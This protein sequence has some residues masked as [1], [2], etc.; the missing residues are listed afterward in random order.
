MKIIVA[1]DSFKGSL[2]S[3]TVSSVI[4][5]TIRKFLSNARIIEV[6]LAD[7]GEGTANVLKDLYPIK[8]PFNTVDA[9]GREITSCYYLDPKN[10]KAFVESA[11]SIGLPLIEPE[12]RSPLT[13]SSFGLG[14]VIK[15]IAIR[16]IK[17]ITVSLGGTAT[18]DAGIGMLSALGWV[19]KD[20]KRQPILPFASS[21]IEVAYI[22]KMKE[23]SL[24][25]GVKF[26]AITDVRNPLFGENGA[27]FVFAP[28]KGAGHHEVVT[29]DEGLRH[30]AHIA[31]TRVLDNCSLADTPG[32]GAAGGLG[33]TF[34]TFLDADLINGIDFILRSLNFTKIIEQADLIITGEGKIDRQSLMGK[35]VSGV[36]K[37][38]LNQN[39]P[40]IAIAGKAEDTNDLKRAGISEIFE[41]SDPGLHP[42]INMQTPVAI[43]N[44]QKT[45]KNMLKSNIFEQILH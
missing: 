12:F 2:D 11:D 13:A 9:I 32:A 23:D 15:E 39:I 8:V 10:E 5:D 3:S 43:K 1:P 33:W 24:L 34:K 28:Q 41:I 42:E 7:G 38:S 22:E 27:S 19:F 14:S 16:G 26:H 44:L 31:E 36:L 20:N 21:L 18:C 30:F 45:V 17:D 6:P 4:A 35:L 37:E 29:L 25:K 40:V